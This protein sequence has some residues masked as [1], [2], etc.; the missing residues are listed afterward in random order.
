MV[1]RS[2][3]LQQL[4]EFADVRL[5][6][7]RPGSEAELLQRLADADVLLNSR[8]TVQ[9]RG[10]LLEQLPNLKMIAVCGIGYDAIDLVA[11]K[12][13]GV[14]VCNIP[15]RTAVV[16]AEHAFGLMLAVSR[17]M[18]AMTAQIRNGGWPAD[19]GTSLISKQVGVIG[20]GNIGCQMIRLCKAFGMNV[21]ASSF[22]EDPDKAKRLGFQYIPR[23]NLL[24]TSDVVSLHVRLSDESRK[25]IGEPQLQQMKPGAILINT[26]RAAVVDTEALVHSLR[27]NHLFGVGVDVY[28]PEPPS[29]DHP[30]L[31]CDNIVLTPHSA[32]QTP[33]GLDMLTLGCVDNIR[34][35]LNGTPQNILG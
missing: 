23:E 14:V 4:R 12:E 32:D 16:V 6:S 35:F 22:H 30:L 11:A 7:D 15:G 33:E 10:P 5:Y 26:A 31:S 8:S 20:T 24:Q 21:V 28:D 3:H 9:V 19:L 13:H 34:E 17:R 2:S 1:G 18:G 27:S 29:P 25:M